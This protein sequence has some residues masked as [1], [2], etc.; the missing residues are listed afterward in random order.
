MFK[1]TIY[2][3]YETSYDRRKKLLEDAARDVRRALGL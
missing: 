3:F 2:R 1:I